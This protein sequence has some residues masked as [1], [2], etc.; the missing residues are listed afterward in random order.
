MFVNMRKCSIKGTT[1]Q[2]MHNCEMYAHYLI[3]KSVALTII[4]TLH[5]YVRSVC[6]A[7]LL[8]A[9]DRFACVTQGVVNT[10]DNR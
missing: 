4:A 3:I 6:Y 1:R 8:G 9:G 7:C 10:E 2:N 5:R